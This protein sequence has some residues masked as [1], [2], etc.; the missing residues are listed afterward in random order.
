M[1]ARTSDT[2]VFRLSFLR[3]SLVAILAVAT[4]LV[5][6]PR[7]FRVARAGCDGVAARAAH[8]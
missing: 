7:S 6:P 2:R 8:Q 5:E 4:P 3:V 1:D